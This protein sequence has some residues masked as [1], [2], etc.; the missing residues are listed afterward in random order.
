MS[1]VSRDRFRQVDD[2]FDAALDLA[3]DE[4][5]AFVT[6][7]CGTDAALRDRVR[8]LLD[9]YD[10]SGG[11]LRAPAVE[12]AAVLLDDAAISP[13]SPPERAGPFR[14]VR[15][16]GHGG[17]GV[18][19]LAEREGGEFD[20]RVA[21]KLVRH[22]GASDAV[23]RRFLEERRILARLEHPRIA[24]LIDGGVTSDG[25]PYFAMELVEG[26]PIDAYCDSQHLSI[27]R[28]LDLFIDVCDAVQYAH[29]HLVI[30]R[31]IKPSN[32]LVRGDGQLKLLDFGIAK[33]LDPVRTDESDATQTGIVALTP[34]YAS[35]EQVRGLPVSTATDTYAL[36]V[37]LYL[38][39]TGRRPYELRGQTPAE[40]ERIV[41]EVEPPR[42]SA[43]AP[44]SIRRKLRG[45]LDLIVMKALHKDPERRYSSALGLREDL[46]HFRAGLAVLARPDSIAYRA[47]KFVRRN[48]AVVAATITTIV[49]LAGAAAF[50]ASQAAEAQRQRDAA[51]LEVQRQRALV[52]TQSVIASD[53]RDAEGRELSPPRRIELAEQLLMQQFGRQPGVVA[54][55]MLELS[56]RLYDLG[57]R[58]A[59][60]SMLARARK[61]ARDAG[62]PVELAAIDCTAAT[63]LVFDDQLDS[64][65]L[66][67]KEAEAALAQPGAGDA[68]VVRAQCLDG[69]GRL[70]VAEGQP[71]S[72]AALHRLAVAAA[73]RG[74]PPTVRLQMTS[75]L[76]EALRA[77]GRTREASV[78]HQRVIAEL[79]SIGFRGTANLPNAMTA[80]TG[81]LFELG[82]LA[83]VDSVVAAAIRA[84]S[85]APGEYSSGMLNFLF[86]LAKLRL[87]E[88][89]SADVW[90]ARSMRDTTEA[91][92]GLSVYL[93]PAL[94]QLRLEQGRVPEARASL[95]TLPSGTFVRRV[96]RAWL[97][98][99]T[100]YAEGDRHG[101]VSMLEDSLRVLAATGAKPPPSLA[102]P[103]VTA[104]EWRLAAGDAR[105]ADSLARLARAAG[106]VDS[107]AL[108]R[109]AYIGRAELVVARA[110][111]SLGAMAEARSAADRAMT[112]LTNGYGSTS[113]ITRRAR[114][115][116]DSL[117][118]R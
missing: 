65:R 52:E 117:T 66:V 30:H 22:L 12:L 31:D 107:V 4:R 26:Q 11:F 24:H 75:G 20:Q 62:L 41:C 50:S 57:E 84:H 54:E 59:E 69:A 58:Q 118:Q 70:L 74:A 63:S 77:A 101:A 61:I 89:D 51:L 95:A 76:A 43:V 48:R 32:I 113:L 71:D 85:R 72:A 28:R 53:T 98:A 2:I 5:E 110:Q 90:I 3:P 39:L 14:I 25:L 21:L 100:R 105:A 42:P 33:L 46:R 82:E 16:L 17:M 18:V 49:A 86:G 29:E 115:F 45:D 15:E 88:T 108:Q 92:G 1:N 23:H 103:F 106:A 99:R 81:A 111:A 38:L 87:G 94:T 114:A 78:Y 56:N 27:E 7:A 34:E 102:M 8:T 97:T 60:R 64:A 91:A 104:A 9:A 73:S 37:L 36:G 93:P 47:R 35:P 68:D 55:V 109:S 10:R 96:N 67:L 80:V 6:N 116:R 13:A 112:A 79:D 19:Y 40:I 83:A 44:E